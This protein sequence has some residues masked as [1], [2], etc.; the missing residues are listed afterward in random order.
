MDAGARDE[1]ERT[2][3]GRWDA[4]DLT[5]AADAAVR[6][7][8]PEVYGFLAAFHH[9]E[10]DAAE[11]WS[12]VTER[13]W[14]GLDRFAWRS[15]FRTWLYTIARNA[16]IR[17]REEK[18]RRAARDA[19]LSGA[20]SEVARVAER[21]RTDTAEWLR[22]TS[23]DRFAALRE[24]LPED[25]RALLVLR[26]DKELSFADVARVMHEGDAPLD[27]AALEREAARLRKRF[28]LVK[29]ELLART[30]ETDGGGRDGP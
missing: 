28:Q 7:Y 21:V 25:D 17:Y 22:T 26:V 8:G 5:G 16:S 11:V 10:E 29:R 27:D 4:G 15:S 1:L 20:A 24:A 13:L 14:A 3:R 9:D 2:I 6:G 19:P 18:R 23:K 12:R 30:R